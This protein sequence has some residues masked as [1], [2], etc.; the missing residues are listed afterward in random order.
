MPATAVTFLA[1]GCSCLLDLVTKIIKCRKHLTG[2]VLISAWV[3]VISVD[4]SKDLSTDTQTYL[5]PYIQSYYI[6]PH[7]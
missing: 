2:D 6:F 5:L 1:V 4:T 7:T 3:W